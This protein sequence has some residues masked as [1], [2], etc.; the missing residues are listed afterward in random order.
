[1]IRLPRK[2]NLFSPVSVK[3]T[4]H[5]GQSHQEFMG[6]ANRRLAYTILVGKVVC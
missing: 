6:Y 3:N 5:C 2:V 1:M 4:L